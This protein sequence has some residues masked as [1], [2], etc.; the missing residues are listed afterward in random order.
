[1]SDVRRIPP[2]GMIARRYCVLE[3]GLSDDQLLYLYSCLI[4]GMRG[5]AMPRPRRDLNLAPSEG[6]TVRDRVTQKLPEIDAVR[7]GEQRLPPK[8]G[9]STSTP[10]PEADPLPF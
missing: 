4:A 6:E 3:E 8:P 9:G 2:D 10:A 5:E 7:A 1:M